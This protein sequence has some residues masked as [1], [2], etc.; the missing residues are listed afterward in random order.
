MALPGDAGIQEG[1]VVQSTDPRDAQGR[2]EALERLY[3]RLVR[4]MMLLAGAWV[5]L[6][7]YVVNVIRPP[8]TIHADAVETGHVE[9]TAV[10]FLMHD[11]DRPAAYLSTWPRVVSELPNGS[12]SL[13][14]FTPE[15]MLRDPGRP[16]AG[17][18]AW[19]CRAA[20]DLTGE[21]PAIAFYDAQGEL[22]AIMTLRADG[23]AVELRDPTG[24]VVF[25]T[26]QGTI[27]DERK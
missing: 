2:L 26:D 24:R 22:Q 8:D 5:L 3:R 9:T 23:P 10:K 25:S 16:P 17:G 19:T 11:S 15:L 12:E 20:F 27:G 13:R 1:R 14:R 4:W 7:L 21:L 18:R 6:A